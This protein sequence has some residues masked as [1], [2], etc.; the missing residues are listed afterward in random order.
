[1]KTK[2][3]PGKWERTIHLSW[4]PGFATTEKWLVINKYLFMDWLQYAL[5][6]NSVPGPQPCSHHLAQ[7]M[8][9]MLSLSMLL[10]MQPWG[11]SLKCCWVHYAIPFCVVAYT[12]SLV[13]PISLLPALKQNLWYHRCCSSITFSLMSSINDF[14]YV[15]H[16]QSGGDTVCFG[17]RL[18]GLYS[19]FYSLALLYWDQLINHHSAQLSMKA[20]WAQ[21]I[22][23]CLINLLWGLNKT[24]CLMC[25]RHSMCLIH[26]VLNI[27]NI[28][29]NQY[30]ESMYVTDLFPL[31]FPIAPSTDCIK[32]KDSI[33][34]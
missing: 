4:T 15:S 10:L 28:H 14:I 25:L 23:L 7:I 26:T 31:L 20:N 16:V 9:S 3:T 11:W 24:V 29:L 6:L 13:D 12:T 8:P 19:W 5:S 1:M 32:S 21:I 30:L 18:V 22:V 27:R 34:T 33:H 17:I 2:M